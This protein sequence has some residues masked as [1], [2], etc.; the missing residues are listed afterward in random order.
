MVIIYR[1]NSFIN[2]QVKKEIMNEE[3]VQLAQKLQQNGI[4]KSRMD[5]IKM[6]ESMLNIKI[7]TSQKSRISNIEYTDEPT[8]EKTPAK[9][10]VDTPVSLGV[11]DYQG[12][13]VQELT[14]ETESQSELLE[15]TENS[16]IQDEPVVI[17]EED[18]VSEEEQKEE[19]LNISEENQTPES[20]EE[21]T[22]Q[23]K[24]SEPESSQDEFT[25]SPYD[26]AVKDFEEDP[27]VPEKT[28]EIP[29]TSENKGKGL[30]QAEK[31][32]TDITKIFNAN[33]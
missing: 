12:K 17:S 27:D 6:A 31:E 25:M 15:N 33:K 32:M 10:A 26:Q 3:V 29:G 23:E 21:E 7:D 5:A 19:Y 4:A 8:I 9:E 24:A 2:Y 18:S 22:T 30:S 28:E 16:D 14:E 13:T 1:D 11:D 20:A